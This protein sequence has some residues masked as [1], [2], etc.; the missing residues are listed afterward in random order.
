MEQQGN[1][2]FILVWHSKDSLP[3]SANPATAVQ[4]NCPLDLAL[5]RLCRRQLIPAQPEFTI[6]AVLS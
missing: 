5:G 6:R 1:G 2:S 3:A 4:K